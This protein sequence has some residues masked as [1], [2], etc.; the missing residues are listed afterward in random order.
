[1]PPIKT[2]SG[3]VREIELVSILLLDVTMF[4]FFCDLIPLNVLFLII[5]LSKLSVG[6]QRTYQFQY[7]IAVPHSTWQFW[8]RFDLLQNLRE[9]GDIS[10]VHGV[11]VWRNAHYYVELGERTP[12]CS[13]KS[14][15]FS[16]LSQ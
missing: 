7:M 11:Q 5:R 2:Y 15:F 12:K 10:K 14:R 1:M 9:S 16:F 6:E 8:K 4:F 13:L 3:G